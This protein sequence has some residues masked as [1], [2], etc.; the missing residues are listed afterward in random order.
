[1][2]V[3]TR[4]NE[5]FSIITWVLCVIVQGILLRGWH[6]LNKGKAAKYTKSQRCRENLVYN[7][8]IDN[9][10]GSVKSMVYYLPCHMSEIFVRMAYASEYS[11][12]SC[13]A[14]YTALPCRVTGSTAREAEEVASG[15]SKSDGTMNV[16]SDFR[17]THCPTGKC[18]WK[19]GARVA[20]AGKREGCG[21]TREGARE[22]FTCTIY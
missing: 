9:Q 6:P 21:Q 3:D 7:L 15:L 12:I 16:L 5:H 17:I 22:V 1:V 10:L 4:G 13:K 19:N 20:R 18:C 11:Y 8:R 2:G 14:P